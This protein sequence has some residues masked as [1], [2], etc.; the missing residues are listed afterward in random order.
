VVE[1][2][3]EGWCTNQSTHETIVVPNQHEPQRS[4]DTDREH[5]SSAPEFRHAVCV[6]SHLGSF[7][8][9]G[10][11]SGGGV[12]IHWRAVMTVIYTSL[13]CSHTRDGPLAGVCGADPMGS[14]SDAY[15]AGFD[16]GGGHFTN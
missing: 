8:L 2:L 13:G 9:V 14:A 7:F 1:S 11:A 12:G 10:S 16:P 6:G 3:V 15:P 4:E 5:K